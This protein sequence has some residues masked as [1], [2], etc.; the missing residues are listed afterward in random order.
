[1]MSPKRSRK[2]SGDVSE[3]RGDL[4]NPISQAHRQLIRITFKRYYPSVNILVPHCL[5]VYHNIKK[6]W[7]QITNIYTKGSCKLPANGLSAD[8]TINV[9]CSAPHGF[10]RY[11][12]EMRT[13]KFCDSVLF[14][15]QN[16]MKSTKQRSGLVEMIPGAILEF[17][18]LESG[19]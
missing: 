8:S 12:S 17:K 6:F 14:Y 7:K 1:M 5:N 3:M 2:H 19:D 4:L 11:S 16:P 13:Y 9:F 15:R 18:G 10:T